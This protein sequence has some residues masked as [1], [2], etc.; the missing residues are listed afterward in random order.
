M[1]AKR[2]R[3][4]R[5]VP[6]TKSAPFSALEGANLLGALVRQELE[7]LQRSDRKMTPTQRGTLMRRCAAMLRELGE[8]TGETLEIPESKLVRMPQLRRLFE[9]VTKALE[10]WPAALAAVSEAMAAVERGEAP[11]GTTT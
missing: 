7:R 9:R 2:S 4:H 8:L 10:P 5:A 11:G 6:A 1:A 3:P